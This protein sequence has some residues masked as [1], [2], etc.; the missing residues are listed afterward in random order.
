MVGLPVIFGFCGRL[1]DFCL[2]TEF[3]NAY[4]SAIRVRGT[5]E[6]IQLSMNPF[7]PC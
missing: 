5:H 3:L 7:S 6:R 1:E 4:K 2:E